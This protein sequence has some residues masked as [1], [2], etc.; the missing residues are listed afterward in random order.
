MY[1]KANLQLSECAMWGRNEQG[2]ISQLWIDFAPRIREILN[3]SKDPDYGC[4]SYVVCS[5]MERAEPGA[6]EYIACLPVS[7]IEKVPEGMVG[8]VVPEQTYA[9]MEAHGIKDIGPTYEYI[10]K[11]W[12]PSSDYL[13]GDGPDFELYPEE[14]DPED[15]E[16][17]LYIFFPVKKK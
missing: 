2:E 8:K 1:K 9:A 4:A 14:F 10:I 12:L 15:P 7:S 16:S 5:C 13:P 17:S 6:F 3:F 11:K